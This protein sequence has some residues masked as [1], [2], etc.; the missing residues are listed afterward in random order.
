[1]PKVV[2]PFCGDPVAV[3]SDGNVEPTCRRCGAW[4]VAAQPARR[5][6]DAVDR[7]SSTMA[8]ET[9]DVAGPTGDLTFVTT[10]YLPDSG[11]PA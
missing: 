10:P 7:L 8:V 5:L 3:F 11:P 1:M 4:V 9:R 6:S 2:C